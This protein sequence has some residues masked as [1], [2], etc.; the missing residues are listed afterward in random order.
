[1]WHAV[2][3]VRFH[4]LER[5]QLKKLEGTI[6]T[7][8][9][10]L[11]NGINSHASIHSLPVEVL[12]MVFLLSL[13]SEDGDIRHSGCKDRPSIHLRARIALTSVCQRWRQIALDMAALWTVI[14]VPGPSAPAFVARSANIPLQLFATYTPERAVGASIGEHA[15]RV[16]DIALNIPVAHRS[17]IPS[18]G[19]VFAFDAPA[20]EF[21]SVTTCCRPFEE[22]RPTLDF[23]A[24]SAVFAGATPRLRMLVL[25]NT[26]WVPAVPCARLTHLHLERGPPTP[27]IPL[28]AFLAR[29]PALT[30]LAVVDVYLSLASAVPLDHAVALPALR[31]LALGIN[32]PM[33]SMRRLLQYFVLP[34]DGLRMRVS[35]PYALRALAGLQPFPALPFRCAFDRLEVDAGPGRLGLRAAGPGKEELVLELSEYRPADQ[36]HAVAVAREMVRLEGVREWTF[37]GPAA[38]DGVVRALV[39]SVGEG[40]ALRR[41]VYVD[42][43][44][45]CG[46]VA[47]SA[48][49][50]VESGKVRAPSYVAAKVETMEEVEIWSPEE[51]VLAELGTEGV[52]LSLKKVAIHYA[53]KK[54]VDVAQMRARLPGV[55]LSMCTEGCTPPRSTDEWDWFAW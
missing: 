17:S 32:Q 8:L 28:L 51:A 3:P 13:P 31:T 34:Q 5:A 25:S 38:C 24:P 20:L 22:S 35:G 46:G 44:V 23:D 50:A 37:R 42:M 9:S 10:L 30:H 4:S 36:K 52:A 18:H 54:E 29:C 53:G 19:P 45:R 21:L 55:E 15:A 48:M 27:L 6:S 7:V 12:G 41:F 11:R 40:A 47:K 43:P 14:D 39:E 49:P 16:R 26:C 33:L 1:M 2:A